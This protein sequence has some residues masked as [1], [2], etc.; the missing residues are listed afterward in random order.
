[1][2]PACQPNCRAGQLLEESDVFA[3]MHNRQSSIQSVAQV[4]GSL[5]RESSLTV[6][7]EQDSLIIDP[8]V[9]TIS[10]GYNGNKDEEKDWKSNHIRWEPVMFVASNER[11]F[12]LLL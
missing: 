7:V 11:N 10:T 3:R 12:I 8:I 6:E 2:I 1:V 4:D 5:S 9:W